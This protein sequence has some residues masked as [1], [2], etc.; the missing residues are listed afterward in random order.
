MVRTLD[1]SKTTILILNDQGKVEPL[2]RMPY[3][4]TKYVVMGG[5][6]V[7]YSA[8]N[9]Q[10]NV[11]VKEVSSKK[12]SVTMD[13]KEQ[14][15]SDVNAVCEAINAH[16]D[17]GKIEPLVGLWRK[18]F[19][20]HFLDFKFTSDTQAN[21]GDPVGRER[22][23]L[24]RQGVFV[25]PKTVTTWIDSWMTYHDGARVAK[26]IFKK[27][28]KDNHNYQ[29]FINGNDEAVCLTGRDEC[30]QPWL[31]FLPPSYANKPIRECEFWLFGV[32]TDQE[33]AT[34][35]QEFQ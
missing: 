1:V 5:A 23:D 21:D 31:H 13:G 2:P 35:E 30:K 14:D 25:I 19:I 32:D 33:D 17:T 7:D 8:S 28:K 18:H 9:G 3:T 15:I 6:Q 27:D 16:K 10:W 34:V 12:F 20:Q 22:L 11:T 26:V 29:V 4:Y 24:S